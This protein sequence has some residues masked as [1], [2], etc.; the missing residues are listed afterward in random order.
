MNIINLFCL[1]ITQNIKS[2]FF[3]RNLLC[4]INCLLIIY[5][6]HSLKLITADL[7]NVLWSS[8]LNWLRLLIFIILNISLILFFLL[9]LIMILIDFTLS[10]IFWINHI[11]DIISQANK[12]FFYCCL[13]LL[14]EYLF[15][16][17]FNCL[18]RIFI[19]NSF[20]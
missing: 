1:S 17:G 18:I 6:I 12:A 20:K 9:L 14:R 3:I 7:I 16:Q 13:I 15:L 8:L 19:N 5:W 2:K 4:L 10:S 11:I